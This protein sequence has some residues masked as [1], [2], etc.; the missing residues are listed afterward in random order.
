MLS[1]SIKHLQFKNLLLYFTNQN[2]KNKT[3]LQV[4]E[5]SK[6]DKFEV[7]VQPESLQESLPQRR[8]K[9]FADFCFLL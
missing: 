2:D 6:L 8:K 5:H 1:Q 9:G 7:P 3:N 4:E